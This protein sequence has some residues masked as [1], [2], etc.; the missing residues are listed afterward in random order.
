M[1]TALAE[2]SPRASTANRSSPPCA[3]SSDAGEA[4]V[5]DARIPGLNAFD[6]NGFWAHNCGEQPLP[7]YGACLL[8]SLN[9]ARFVDAAVYRRRRGSM[10]RALAAL[11][12]DAVRMMDNII[13][14][15]RLSAAGAA[16]GGAAA[17][18]ASGSAS[19]GWPTR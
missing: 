19:P 2:L 4:E 16:G 18:G 8:G 6:A 5:F 1:R 3:R 12:P 17:S 10:A 13:D 15:S 11:V 14:I 9:L 7:P